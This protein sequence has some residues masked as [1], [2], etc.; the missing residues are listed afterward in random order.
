MKK[1]M[2]TICIA[3]F[4]LQGR[5][6]FLPVYGS[7]VVISQPTH[8]DLYISGGTVRIEAP[9]QGDVV[10]CGGNVIISDTVRGSILLA[11]GDVTINGYTVG[12]IRCAGGRVHING[13]IG[14]DLVA[15]AGEITTSN[16]TV[17]NGGILLGGG[18][19]VINGTVLDK[20]I[21]SAGDL[22]LNATV[23]HELKSKSGKITVNG[24]IKG[25][26]TLAANTITI[27]ANAA[28]NDSVHYWTPD[29]KVDFRQS[30]LAGKPVYDA[31]LKIQS[32]SWAYLGFATLLMML[33]YLMAVLAVI[34]LLQVV[35]RRAM[36]KA[37]AEAVL[38]PGAS[39]GWGL[40]FLVATPVIAVVLVVT[41]IGI[42][43]GLVLL[44]LYII[45]IIFSLSIT[46][47]V[48][49]NWLKLRFK[50]N[51]GDGK[52]I[53]FAFLLFIGF[54]MLSAIPFFGWI[55]GLTLVSMALGAV[56]LSARRK[57]AVIA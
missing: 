45:V 48:A 41:L 2:F 26:A 31:S 38:K 54:K 55:I 56:I 47:V 7:E 42:P 30:V 43:L 25:P 23:E 52:L 14:G 34:V 4:A 51:W 32:S 9:V 5:A 16:K 39:L 35:L 24:T 40:L 15:G 1:I 57:G 50:T 27:G 11:G 6:A 22:T 36:E 18:T 49:S 19:V 8:E 12:H 44:A 53:L 17:I 29:N 3:L 13:S 10:V 28:F 37:G 46:S 21:A 20:V 33:W